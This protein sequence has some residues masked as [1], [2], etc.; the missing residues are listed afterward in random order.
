MIESG[1]NSHP[2]FQKSV[3]QGGFTL[4][5]LL[6]AMVVTAIL[7]TAMVTNFIS[8]QRSAAIVRETAYMQQQLRG[9]MYIMEQSIRIAG[10]NPLDADFF[11]IQEVFKRNVTDGDP[12]V[13]GSPALLLAADWSP[14]ALTHQNG[15]LDPVEQPLFLLSDQNGDGMTDLVRVLAGDRQVVAENIERI[16]FSYA[17]EDGSGDVFRDGAGNLVWAIDTNN[18]NLLDTNIADN[19]NLGPI[20]LDRIRLV[21]VQML[22]RAQNPSPNFLSPVFVLGDQPPAGGD[23]FRRRLLDRVLECRNIGL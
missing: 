3:D 18:D 8:Q 7:G 13:E 12:D 10:F 21:R 20:P 14:G 22:A 19:T 17:F 4:I 6:I 2:F 9:A 15:I 23:G 11:G 1:R 16:L 5:E